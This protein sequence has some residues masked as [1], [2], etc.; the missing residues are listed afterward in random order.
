[1][2]TVTAFED[3]AMAAN[4]RRQ[5]VHDFCFPQSVVLKLYERAEVAFEDDE[6]QLVELFGRR[7]YAFAGSGGGTYASVDLHGREPASSPV[8]APCKEFGR[9]TTKR[10]ALL[11]R[12]KSSG[13]EWMLPVL[14]SIADVDFL[15]GAWTDDL[16]RHYKSESEQLEECWHLSMKA[17]PR[18]CEEKFPEIGD[19][20]TLRRDLSTPIRGRVQEV[21][22]DRRQATAYVLLCDIQK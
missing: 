9:L 13:S 1:M 5:S 17:I 18:V 14:D 22:R 12:L 15:V 16:G 4:R 20:L 11:K 21:V 6:L 10:S 8:I 3:P 7:P 2:S 19:L